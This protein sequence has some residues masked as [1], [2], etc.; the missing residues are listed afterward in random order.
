M[1]YKCY[2]PKLRS[3]KNYGGKGVTVCDEWLCNEKTG[4]N[5]KGWLAFEKWAI[6]NGYTEGLTLDRINTE[7]GYSPENC[8]LVSLK[9]QNNNI[10]YTRII[11]YKGKTQSVPEWSRE[12]HIPCNT[13]LKRLNRLHWSVEEAFLTPIGVSKSTKYKNTAPKLNNILRDM[14]ARC[15]NLHNKDY[16]WYGAR[17]I[18]VCDEWLN[19]E[20][21]LDKHNTT[22]GCLAFK[23]WALSHGYKEGLTIDRINSEK[24]YSPDNCRWI[25]IQDQQSNKSSNHWITYKGET[26]T[27]L[28]WS[29]ELNVWH[30]TLRHRICNLHW[31]VEQAFE[32]PV[33]SNRK[34]VKK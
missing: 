8:R 20:K 15:Y 22:K 3:Y 30:G 26:K 6:S 10:G 23:D 25:T 28:Q 27:L 31:S 33:I 4:K 12:L 21:V 18:K 29:R 1:K 2:N 32:T 5:I 11:T 13:I 16:R 14:K 19:T 7:Y 9:Y 17:G 24:D 34:S